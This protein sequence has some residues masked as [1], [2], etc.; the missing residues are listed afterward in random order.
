MND[1]GIC[2]TE[3]P[4]PGV[5][6][7]SVAKSATLDREIILTYH[8]NKH[9]ICVIM[10]VNF[11]NLYYCI[12]MQLSTQV[13]SVMFFQFEVSSGF[14]ELLNKTNSEVCPSNLRV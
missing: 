12:V 3:V 4:K 9:R 2:V 5:C 10:Y 14:V 11:L 13:Q 7:N 6:K 1:G 8:K